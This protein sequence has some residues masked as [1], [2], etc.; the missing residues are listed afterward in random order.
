LRLHLFRRGARSLISQALD[1]GT[2]VSIG[3]VAIVVTTRL[4]RQNYLAESRV[5]LTIV[6]QHIMIELTIVFQHIM[7]E[8]TLMIQV[9]G[10]EDTIRLSRSSIWI[11]ADDVGR[12]GM[13]VRIGYVGNDGLS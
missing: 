11:D 13:I 2:G 10:E 8:L 3:T 12:D 1:I 6:F 5:E 7:I 4:H 9:Q